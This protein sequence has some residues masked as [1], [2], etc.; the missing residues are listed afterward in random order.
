MSQIP[1]TIRPGGLDISKMCYIFGQSSEVYGLIFK[2]I[3]LEIIGERYTFEDQRVFELKC[4]NPDTG[5]LHARRTYWTEMLYRAHMASVASLLRTVGWIE[6]AIREHD[7]GSLY[8]CA[9]AFRSLIESA[10]DIG[11]SLGAVPYTLATIKHQVKAEIAGR[12]QEPM[13]TSRE[14]EDALIHFTHARKV[15]KGE[16]A[17]ESHRAL[18][19]YKYVGYVDRMQ[20]PG[21]NEFYAQLCEIVHPAEGSVSVS[22]ISE[23]GAWL[24]DLDNEGRVLK[25]MLDQRRTTLAGVLVASFN[26]PL[27]TLRTLQSFGLFKKLPSLRKYRFDNI[28]E[29][30]RIAPLLRS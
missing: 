21:V 28:P 1:L 2:D 14:L 7:A 20:I 18:Q 26:A 11:I 17:P 25:M 19:S 15:Q 30:N 3:Y 6:V 24:A 8:G 9:S 22:F 27:L 23:G 16:E 13:L 5:M 4:R 12:S 29:W 10:G